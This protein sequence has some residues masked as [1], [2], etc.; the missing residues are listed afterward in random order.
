MIDPSYSPIA[1]VHAVNYRDRMLLAWA[2]RTN[3]VAR[4]GALSYRFADLP[5]HLDPPSNIE[6]SQAEVY[7]F[8]LQPLPYGKRYSA[9]LTRDGVGRYRIT[10]WMSQTL[11][12]VTT[13]T[14]N[15][16]KAEGID[17]RAYHGR[18]NGPGMLCSLRLSK[19]QAEWTV[20]ANYGSGW[21]DLCAESNLRRARA[22]LRAYE[23]NAPGVPYRLKVARVAQT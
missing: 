11:A 21:E 14:S 10:T 22:D 3:H 13:F 8:T 1:Y 20:Q 5:A 7:N 19:W 23:E 17:G 15:G 12:T 9:Y 2:R 4:N 6:R 16:Y 18:H